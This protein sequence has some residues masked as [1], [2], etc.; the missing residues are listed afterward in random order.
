MGGPLI[1]RSTLILPVNVPR[2]VEGAHRRGA[3]AIMLDLEDAVPLQEKDPA[4]RLIREAVSLA[5]RGGAEIFVR[6]NHD[7]AHLARD[8]EASV[9]ADVDGVCFP[10]TESARE[11]EH[12][13]AQIA[14]V[15]RI[16]GI[17]PGRIEIAP[18][19]ESPR[20]VLN[21]E[22]IANASRRVRTIALGP[23]DYCLALGVEPSSDGAELHY[24]LSRLVTA[25]KAVGIAPLGLMGSIAGFRDLAAF[26]R[27]ASRARDLGCVGASCIHPDQVAVLNR[28]FSPP[29]V[30]V[31]RARRAVEVFEAGLRNGTASVSVDGAMVD[32]PVYR[33]AQQLLDRA[34]AIADVEAR[35]ASALARLI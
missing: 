16:R 6:V 14:D 3:D 8:L 20:G 12:L 4:R 27:A 2:F 19:I 30:A 7:P 10:K 11:V 26:E 15:E 17:A 28:G 25:C 22:S 13:E 33:R 23:E 18:L 1:R 21:L 5:S 29:A 31:D 34:A 35:K 9:H 24:A 32:T